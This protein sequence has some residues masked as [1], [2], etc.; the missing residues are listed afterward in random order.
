ML[1]HMRFFILSA[2]ACFL[3]LLLSAELKFSLHAAERMIQGDAVVIDLVGINASD[4]PVDFNAPPSLPLTIYVGT[5]VHAG[6]MHALQSTPATVPASGYLRVQ[7][8][9]ELP[10]ERAATAI[11]ESHTPDGDTLRTVLAIPSPAGPPMPPS[12]AGVGSMAAT[13]EPAATPAPN[14]VPGRTGGAF[15]TMASGNE[16]GLERSFAGR[17]GLHE[18]MYFVYGNEDLG[19]KFQ[20]SFKY[21]LF[22]QAVFSETKSASSF[23]FGYTQR[24]LWDID[25]ASSPFYD[26]SYMPSLFF[27]YANAR[28][29]SG[30]GWFHWLGTQGGILHESNG[31]GGPAS[32]SLNTV[33][34]RSAWALGPLDNW[35][36]LVVPEVFT[37]VGGLSNNEA[38]RDYRGYGQVT[39]TFGKGD[40]PALSYTGRSG[41]D[42]ENITTQLDLTIPFT[43]RFLDFGTYFLAQYFDGYGEN[44]LDYDDRTRSLRFGITL[45]R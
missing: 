17:L 16:T 6:E 24:S 2:L 34:A 22:G 18:P 25:G 45:V 38:I 9:L 37:Y 28:P 42:F 27:E 7:Y 12:A 32:R 39:V 43:T 41:R 33:F 5:E 3:P 10:F 14:R 40:G 30:N 11:V 35:H 23:Q 31:Q 36:L 29:E 44:L 4:R 21:R 26:T 20:I 19:A 13:D 1:S 15:A 8:R